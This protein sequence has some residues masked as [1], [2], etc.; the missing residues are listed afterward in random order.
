MPWLSLGFDV[1]QDEAEALAALL[2]DN[3]A[4]AVSFNEIGD[5]PLY[6]PEPGTTPLWDR[7]RVVGLFDAGTDTARLLGRLRREMQALPEPDIGELGDRDWVR[8][9]RRGF[10]PVCFA[11]RL[12]VCPGW[13]DCPQPDMPHVMLDPGLAFGTGTHPTTRLCLEWLACS[14]GVEGRRLADY[15]C[16]SGI[17]AI[18][19]LKLGAADA[20]AIDNDPQA[21]QATLDN[22]LANTV[23]DR[24]AVAAPDDIEGRV[25]DVIVANILLAPLK[26]LEPVFRRH[27]DAAGGELVLSG[28]LSGQADELLGSY[29]DWLQWSDP[30]E[31]EGWAL[32]HGRRTG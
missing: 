17:L 6:E 29:G 19:A 12:W 13:D 24:L 2:E 18:A 30:V 16:G 4:L 5:D 32:L 7:V 1:A 9:G 26:S 10:G 20:V 25:F 27:L 11:G 21:L 28:I 14:A 15:G 23:E 22:A 31:L 3:N 8:E